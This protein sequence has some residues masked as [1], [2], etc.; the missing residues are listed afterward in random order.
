MQLLFFQV[1]INNCWM[2]I[3]VARHKCIVALK[4]KCLSPTSIRFCN[5]KFLRFNMLTHDCTNS[6]CDEGI[7]Q[8]KTLSKPKRFWNSSASFY[9]FNELRC[10]SQVPLRLDHIANHT[11]RQKF[12]KFLQSS[13]F[14]LTIWKWNK[15]QNVILSPK[16]LVL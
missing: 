16:S 2:L 13:F 7:A 5:Q 12:R 15:L 11:S 14:Q 8:G 3:S 10:P 9:S 4:V 1:P 6:N